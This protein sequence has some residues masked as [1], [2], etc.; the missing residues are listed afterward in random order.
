MLSNASVGIAS[1]LLK[2]SAVRAAIRSPSQ[3]CNQNV[4]YPARPRELRP[5]PDLKGAGNVWSRIC[6]ESGHETR[7][8]KICGAFVHLTQCPAVWWINDIIVHNKEDVV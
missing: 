2:P 4:E 3:S 5:T 8:E 1:H 6:P 7:R